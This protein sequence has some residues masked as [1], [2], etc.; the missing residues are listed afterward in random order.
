[1]NK[2]LAKLDIYGVFSGASLIA[3]GLT[4]LLFGLAVIG[5][6]IHGV[7]ELALAFPN[8]KVAIIAI[9]I[10][11]V[12]FVLG[13]LF[14]FLEFVEGVSTMMMYLGYFVLFWGYVLVPVYIG[15]HFYGF[16]KITPW[17]ELVGYYA[18]MMVAVF[19]FVYSSKPKE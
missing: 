1:M 5:F 19:V 15:F 6:V 10:I 18:A 3:I 14:R 11:G 13:R 9:G 17:P 2:F 7:I 8:Y 4:L 16:I 12:T